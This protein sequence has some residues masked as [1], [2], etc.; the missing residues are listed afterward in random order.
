VQA[1]RRSMVR[2]PRISNILYIDLPL[3]VLHVHMSVQVRRC[4]CTCVLT[5]ACV[6]ARARVWEKCMFVPVCVHAQKRE[7]TA[8]Q[9][10]LGTV[11]Y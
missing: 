9:P 7:K 10:F 2:V 3:G 4:A 6:C 5:C 11:R 8:D 1:D